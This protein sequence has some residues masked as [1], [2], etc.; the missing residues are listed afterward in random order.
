VKTLLAITLFGCALGCKL[1]ASL[2]HRCV[3][4][5]DCL[6]GRVCQKSVCVDPAEAGSP[7]PNYMF[8]TSEL[9]PT[10]FQPL[11]VAD[12]RCNAA[13]QAAGLPGDF[14]AW[15]STAAIY[16]RD[17]IAGARGWIRP[18]GAPFA[19]TVDDIT[20][21]AIF[22]P[23]L[24]D[25][26][27]HEVRG[28][29]SDPIATGTNP[30]GYNDPG[31]N[32]HEWANDEAGSVTAGITEAT[33]DGW[34]SLVSGTCGTPMRIYCFGVDQSFPVAPAPVSGGKLAFVTD[35]AFPCVGGVVAANTMCDTEAAGAGLAGTFR[36]L[37]ATD[38]APAASR[39]PDGVAPWVRP[40]GVVLN[41]TGT[42]LFDSVTLRA[43]FNVT[44]TG[45][46][47]GANQGAYSGA[48][49]PRSDPAGTLSNTCNDW[50]DIV[51]GGEYGWVAR[52]D[53][54]WWDVGN[55][56]CQWNMGHLYCLE[57]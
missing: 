46:Y 3:D 40:D 6:T 52:S 31:A 1:D 27:G 13:A 25:E 43:P 26:N 17:R 32:C 37:L 10:R 9:G 21:G 23:P 55:T 34:T 30:F 19:D 15:L 12:D 47:L 2:K 33:T 20:S 56:A 4:D 11:T 38:G 48:M 45:H 54:T 29:E 41:A 44:A 49:T 16:A 22:N 36:A 35:E 7:R 51:G 5:S 50:Q 39:F 18:D 42:S 53:A 28:G 57:L 8:V 14:R 24:I